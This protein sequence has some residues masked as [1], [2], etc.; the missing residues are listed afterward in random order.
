MCIR[1]RYY[2]YTVEEIGNINIKPHSRYTERPA[3]PPSESS[4]QIR[5][6]V[7][8][9]EELEAFRDLI[10]DAVLSTGQDNTRCV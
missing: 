8:T 4:R 6:A 1:D 3:H 5:E 2:Y 7:L 9:D 10:R